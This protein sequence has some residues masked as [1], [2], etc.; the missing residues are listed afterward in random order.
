MA[1]HFRKMAQNTP[2]TKSVCCLLVFLSSQLYAGGDSPASSYQLS[3]ATSKHLAPPQ[4]ASTPSPNTYPHA[5]KH[6]KQ[7]ALLPYEA[8][9]QIKHDNL[10]T[11]GSRQLQHQGDDWLLSQRANILFLKVE[12]HS[13][14]EQYKNTLRPRNYRYENSVSKKQQQ[15]INFDWPRKVVSD[16]QARKP[17]SKPLRD[18]TYDQLS[19]QLALR[20][21][22]ISGASADTFSQTIVKKGKFKTYQFE[23]MGEEFIDSPLGKVRTV[24][25]RR[26]RAERDSETFIWLAP[27]WNYL[28]VRMRQED[29]DGLFSLELLRATLDGKPLPPSHKS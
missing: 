11:N 26:Y 3:A 7:T 12:E 15:N 17:W 29:E 9:Y 27:A 25:L 10:S 2:L 19:G 5:T 20:Q 24:K 8:S 18:A 1:N 21:Q 28:I 23:N 4:L 13:T 14:I 6:Q 22:L 16:R